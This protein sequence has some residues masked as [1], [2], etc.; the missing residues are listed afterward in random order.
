[1][2]TTSRRWSEE[3]D[4]TTAHPPAWSFCDFPL[5]LLD[6]LRRGGQVGEVLLA[7]PAAVALPAGP[8]KAYPPRQVVAAGSNAYGQLG[9]DQPSAHR[10]TNLF[11]PRQVP[12]PGDVQEIA[13]GGYSAYAI[14]QLS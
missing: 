10:P 9:I 14:V 5:H 6:V 7:L 3:P 8:A 2:I 13:A 11:R 4:P 12:G 1:M